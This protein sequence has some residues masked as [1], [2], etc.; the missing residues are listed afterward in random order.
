MIYDLYGQWDEDIRQIRRVILGHTNIPEIT[1]WSLPLDYAGVNPA[2]VN[3][4]LAYYAR[5]YTVADLNY[6]GVGCKWSGTSRPAPCINFGGIMSLEEIERMV[7]DEPAISLKLLPKYMMMELK[8]GNQWI[9]HD[10]D[11]TIYMKKWAS[12]RC[13]GGIMV[14]SVDMFSG[15]GSGDTRTIKATEA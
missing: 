2:K 5:G 7:R 6:N 4:G 10:K 12:S 15:S 14:W 1:N 3:M 11:D 13:F 9:G 8:F